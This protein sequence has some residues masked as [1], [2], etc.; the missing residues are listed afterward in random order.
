MDVMF[1]AVV[2][3]ALA[4][5]LALFSYVELSDPSLWRPSRR[6]LT[7]ICVL[8]GISWPFA[9]LV[10]AMFGSV[11]IG[12]VIVMKIFSAVMDLLEHREWQPRRNPP[13]TV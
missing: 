12:L 8:I 10:V 9:L 2:Y 11:F 6:L 13:K 5:A 1:S 4:S 7:A 3:G